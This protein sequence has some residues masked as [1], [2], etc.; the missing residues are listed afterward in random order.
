MS[1]DFQHKLKSLSY[2]SF[3]HNQARQFGYDDLFD[4]KR[5]LVLS[6]TMMCSHP[7]FMHVQQFDQE[8]DAICNLGIDGICVIDSTNGLMPPWLEKHSAQLIGLVDPACQFVS[9]VKEAVDN[10][11]PLDTLAR[12]WQYMAII[13]NGS[14]ERFWQVP[15][16]IG[17]S[18]VHYKNSNYQYRGLN[19]EVLKKYLIDTPQSNK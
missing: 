11:K 10:D 14:I 7:S 6:L 8:F 3:Y 9:A 15:Y 16:K 2:K 13:D 17:M 5:V 18:L 1:V 19:P 12:Y 4:Q